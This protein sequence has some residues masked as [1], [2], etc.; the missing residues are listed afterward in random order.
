MN[1]ELLSISEAAKLLD[2][3]E[4]TLRDWDIE[5]KFKAHRTAGGHRRY[6]LAQCREYLEKNPPKPKK[7]TKITCDVKRV[8]KWESSGYLDSCE[9]REKQILAMLLDNAQKVY[10][11][12]PCDNLEISS[13]Q[14][15]W[16][17]QQVFLRSK[18]KKMVAIQPMTG[19]CTMV[20]YMEHNKKTTSIQS[21]AVGANILKLDTPLIQG[22]DFE[23]AKEAYANALATEIDMCIL[24]ELPFFDVELLCEQN[25]ESNLYDYMILPESLY[26]KFKD[27]EMLK[28]IDLFPTKLIVQPETYLPRAAAGKYP[29]STL[30]LPVFSPYVLLWIGPP[31]VTTHSIMA[32]WGWATKASNHASENCNTTGVL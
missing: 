32:R 17:T 30:E 1:E 16:L 5:K 8:L 18:F 6:T 9:S 13:N 23:T 12:N 19:P 14:Y 4:Q 26:E 22:L 10:T 3:C 15:L 20:Y 7:E 21:K 28:G 11:T 31:L 25:V 24:K 27:S 2:V 29:T